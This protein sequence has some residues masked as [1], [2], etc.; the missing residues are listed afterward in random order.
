LLFV[1]DSEFLQKLTISIIE[2]IRQ[3]M[4]LNFEVIAAS[5]GE[6]AF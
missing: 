1:D 4:M 6:E 5:N 2:K 3:A